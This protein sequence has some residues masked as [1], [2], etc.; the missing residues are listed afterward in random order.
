M[1]NA[2][3]QIYG[4]VVE[5][6][7]S[8][9]A[10]L[11]GRIDRPKEKEPIAWAIFA[12]CFTCT[13]SINAASRTA[14]G[15]AENGFGVLRFDFTGLGR[16]EGEFAQTTF[17]SN[18][19]DVVSAAGWLSQSHG[20]PEL[21]VGHSLGGAAVLHAGG[22]IPSCKA[23]AT[24]GAPADPAHVRHLMAAHVEQI[25]REGMAKVHIGGRP[26]EIGKGFIEDLEAHDPKSVI[27]AL[28]CAVLVA[29]SPTDTLVGIENAG[30]IYSW[31][32]HPKSFLS[33]GKVNGAD[34][35][36]LLSDMNDASYFADVLAAWALRHLA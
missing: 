25:E 34:A 4:E 16:S 30:D 5:F 26:V 24:V 19:D 23:V 2:P 28:R 8:L 33:L 29:H 27:G 7:G 11:T 17:A 1:S 9:G 12:H 20:E 31:A 18:V 21:L 14:R 13:S 35:D 22:R 6:P 32:K 36:H 3:L 15:L 10:T